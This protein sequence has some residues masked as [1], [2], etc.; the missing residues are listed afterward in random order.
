MLLEGYYNVILPCEF[1]M[2]VASE[3]KD[4]LVS[5]ADGSPVL[6]SNK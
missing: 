6:T 1:L 3:P 5:H 2:L 4:G